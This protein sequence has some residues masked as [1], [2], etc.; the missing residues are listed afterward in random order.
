M[1][2]FRALGALAVMVAWLAAGPATAAPAPTAADSIDALIE[3]EMARHAIPGLVLAVV[4]AG[5]TTKLAAYGQANVEL[6]VP[7]SAATLFPLASTGKSISATAILLLVQDGAIGL[8]QPIAELLV[9]LPDPWGGVTVRQ[10]LTHTSGL[11]D[12]ALEPGRPELIADSWAEALPRLAAM[13]LAF[14]PGERWAYNQTNYVLLG[15]VIERVSGMPFEE[16]IRERILDPAGMDATVYGD[17][18]DVVPGRATSYE[19]DD[20]RLRHRSSLVFPRYVRMAA[21]LNSSAPD[22]VRWIRALTREGCCARI[23][24]GRCGPRS[25]WPMDPRSGW[26]GL[27]S[28]TGWDGSS[29]IGRVVERSAI[30]VAIPARSA[31]SS[32]TTWPSSCCTMAARVRMR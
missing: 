1:R 20:G 2:R 6:G 27:R 4:R 3:A 13:P 19:A 12:V 28:G 17:F 22:M 8:D 31:I 25:S 5:E 30:P 32:M 29:T 18:L 15:Q 16:F 11:P 24:A 10:L 7:T 26:T 14:P 21:G 23:C 9:G